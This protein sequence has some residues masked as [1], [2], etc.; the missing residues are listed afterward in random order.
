[1]ISPFM[2]ALW[3]QISFCMLFMYVSSIGI[4]IYYTMKQRKHRIRNMVHSPKSANNL[5]YC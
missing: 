3:L 4:S 5:Q 2:F 1:M